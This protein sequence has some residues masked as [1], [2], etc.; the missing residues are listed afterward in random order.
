MVKPRSQQQGRDRDVVVGEMARGG[1]DHIVFA[2]IMEGEDWRNG[3]WCK[4]KFVNQRAVR[5]A[6]EIRGQLRRLCSRMIKGNR[7]SSAGTEEEGER[8][9]LQALAAGHVF[10]AARIGSDGRYRTMRGGTAVEVHPGS[11]FG[12]FGRFSEYVVYGNTEDGREGTVRICNVSGID[13]NWLLREGG[14]KVYMKKGGVG[15]V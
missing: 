10:N 6:D 7:L 14:D 13:G 1:G 3:G 5:K 2:R 4:E 12:R 15:G 9:I 8:L 11:V